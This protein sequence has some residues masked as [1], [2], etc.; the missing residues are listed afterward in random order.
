MLSE[1]AHIYCYLSAIKLT[2]FCLD[3]FSNVRSTDVKRHFTSVV[4]PSVDNEQ[5]ITN[6]LLVASTMT[7]DPHS[8]VESSMITPMQTQSNGQDKISMLLI[9]TSV[10]S[11]V[12]F[13]LSTVVIFIICTIIIIKRRHG[14]R[15]ETHLKRDGRSISQTRFINSIKKQDETVV[16]PVYGGMPINN[17]NLGLPVVPLF[18]Q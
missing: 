18:T 3:S 1:G 16:N 10:L 2:K 12:I 13:I 15:K 17:M 7:S 14:R 6:Q 11:A 4:S 9:A 8:L 5:N